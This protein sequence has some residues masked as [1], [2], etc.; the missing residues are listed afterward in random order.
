M[1]CRTLPKFRSRLEKGSCVLEVPWQGQTNSLTRMPDLI[2]AYGKPEARVFRVGYLI[3]EPAP[4]MKRPPSALTI[5]VVLA[6]H[7]CRRP[8]HPAHRT[9]TDLYLP[10]ARPRHKAKRILCG[11][12]SPDNYGG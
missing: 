6:I 2:V 1:G 10:S 3:E 7:L 4:S 9:R 8:L 11:G 5:S 12:Y